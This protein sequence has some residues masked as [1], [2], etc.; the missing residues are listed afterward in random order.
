M[1]SSSSP[2]QPSGAAV[3]SGLLLALYGCEASA[4][5]AALA[6]NRYFNLL[7]TLTV[8]Q[9]AIIAARMGAWAQSQE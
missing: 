7:G 6:L 2:R 4:V 8:R 5:V 9:L 3:D 1:S